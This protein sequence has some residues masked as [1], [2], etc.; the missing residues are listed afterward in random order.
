M[1]SLPS[2]KTLWPG[3]LSVRSTAIYPPLLLFSGEGD[4][5][6]AKL[7]AGSLHS[8]EDWEELLLPEIKRRRELG[9]EA[10]FRADV[11][12]AKMELGSISY[13]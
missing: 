9:K 6:G 2:D 8:A 3:V 11:A 5:F 10:V 12:F 1:R 4:C 7:R 13:I